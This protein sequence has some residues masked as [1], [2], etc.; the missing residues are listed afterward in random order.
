MIEISASQADQHIKHKRW[1]EPRDVA[2]AVATRAAMLERQGIDPGLA[3][4]ADIVR[5]IELQ[6]T[7][8]RSDEIAE[9]FI[10]GLFVVVL[11]GIYFGFLA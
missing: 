11:L 1:A 4:S 6:Q 5:Q 10:V 2:Q 7:A 3:Y 8:R 9:R